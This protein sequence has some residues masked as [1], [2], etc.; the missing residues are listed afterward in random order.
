M[1]ALMSGERRPS[2]RSWI[3]V[4]D[5]ATNY[6]RPQISVFPV[7]VLESG[8]ADTTTLPLPAPDRAPEP[9]CQAW[10]AFFVEGIGARP[11]G[12]VALSRW[13]DGGPTRVIS[14]DPARHSLVLQ[15]VLRFSTGDVTELPNRQ[16][17]FLMGITVTAGTKPFLLL[18]LLRRP[19]GSY[20]ETVL[21]PRDE[22]QGWSAFIHTPGDTTEMSFYALEDP[23]A[24]RSACRMP[25]RAES[26]R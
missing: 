15:P 26:S 14:V 7:S 18:G 21:A 19:D 2:R 22:E 4:L 10:S 3:F 8:S 25:A 6:P 12:L 16:A 24:S 20:S 13:E 11:T 1:V 17:T 23:V 5:E 9:P